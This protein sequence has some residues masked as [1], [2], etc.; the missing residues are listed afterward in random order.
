MQVNSEDIT[1]A[2]GQ[3]PHP[4]DAQYGKWR[5]AV[6]QD[7]QESIDA[8]KLYFLYDP[9]ADE[10]S[11]TSGQR[12]GYPGLIIFDL[13]FKC[14]AGEISIHSP[15]KMKFLFALKCPSPQGGSAFVLVT[16]E[17]VYGQVR[18]NV[19][20]IDLAQDGLSIANVRP[21]IQQALTIGG[22]YICSM[23]EDQPEI[24]VMANPGLQIWRINCMAESAQPPVAQF[25]VPGA[26]LNHFYDGFLNNGNIIFLS[27]TPDGH[28][29]NTRVH[30]LSLNNP[31]HITSQNCSGDPQRGMPIPRKQCGFDSVTNAILMAGGEVD[32]G[33]GFERLVDYWVLNTQT[34][35]W[36]QIPSQMPC[37][38]IEP[39]LT[40]CHSGTI[41]VWGDFDQ[42]LPGMPQHGT[43]LRI[44]RVSGLEKASHPPA[45]STYNPA[46]P[47]Y[48]SLD[49]KSGGNPPYPS[50]P[51]NQQYP[52]N[53]YGG[54]GGQQAPPY[55]SYNPN[56]SNYGNAGYQG[57]PS[58]DQYGNAGYGGQPGFDPNQQ[59]GYTQTA[60]GQNAYYPTQKKK[61]SCS[62][63]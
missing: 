3:A 53:P 45:Y 48:P 14:F 39:R 52:S 18:L 46:P 44:L 59:G 56:Q 43:H 33:N 28:F 49:E 20:R 16:E 35:Q 17:E 22:E 13:N 1:V 12:K 54:Q 21:L 42:P 4:L 2:W 11:G 51:S 15:G 40:A 34:F 55:P 38:L 8:T 61:K 19:S 31:Q 26:D 6:F 23:R 47:A 32:R 24:V 50:N 63:Q 41:Y 10:Q 5:M 30:L 57:G 62:I 25:T 37:P 58:N 36:L 9:Q 60:D 29:D 7:V 27:A